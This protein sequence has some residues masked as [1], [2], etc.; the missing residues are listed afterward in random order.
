MHETLSFFLEVLGIELRVSHLWDKCF[1]TW[2]IPL[3]LCFK[4]VF[5]IEFHAFAWL[6]LD[7]DPPISAF[8]VAGITNLP[9]QVQPMNLFL[10]LN[11]FFFHFFF[12]FYLITDCP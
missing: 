2:V 4:F 11:F 7:Q 8:W 3:V 5:Q 1:T 12:P 9:H 10:L 6:D